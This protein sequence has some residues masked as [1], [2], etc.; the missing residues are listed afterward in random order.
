MLWTRITGEEVL[1]GNSYFIWLIIPGEA[2]L[3]GK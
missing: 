2:A 1:A 3:A